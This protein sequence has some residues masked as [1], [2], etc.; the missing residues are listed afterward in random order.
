[1]EGAPIRSRGLFSPDSFPSSR[2]RSLSLAIRVIKSVSRFL[3]PLLLLLFLFF[4]SSL[5][6]AHALPRSLFLQ[7]AA[8]GTLQTRAYILLF[9]CSTQRGQR[10]GLFFVSR[11]D[12]CNAI[13]DLLPKESRFHFGG[14][15]SS[16]DIHCCAVY[17]SSLYADYVLHSRRA[18]V[19]NIKFIIIAYFSLCTRRVA[20]KLPFE[21]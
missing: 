9:R 7:I 11:R 19:A 16:R 4:F 3:I 5:H 2:V 17:I 6:K 8:A 13:R 15:S 10:R 12:A 18:C 1:M 21:I 20:Q 14:L